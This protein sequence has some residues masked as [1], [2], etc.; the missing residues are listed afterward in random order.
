MLQKQH[1]VHTDKDGDLYAAQ[2]E[3]LDSWCWS[4]PA[5]TVTASSA[6]SATAVFNI[7]I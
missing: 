1:C 2:Q 6:A 5:V 3:N 7:D 4:V